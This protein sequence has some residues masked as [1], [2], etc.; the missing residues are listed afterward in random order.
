M[1]VFNCSMS[2]MSYFNNFVI[3]LVGIGHFE[4]KR[5]VKSRF[6]VRINKS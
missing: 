2:D 5:V 4:L 3:T 6:S 1:N